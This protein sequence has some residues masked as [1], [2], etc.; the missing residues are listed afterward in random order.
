MYTQ[1]I[2]NNTIFKQKMYQLKIIL[3]EELNLPPWK[4]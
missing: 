3:P 1:V 2:H 4:L